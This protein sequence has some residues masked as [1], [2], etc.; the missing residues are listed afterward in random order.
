[1]KSALCDNIMSLIDYYKWEMYHLNVHAL[2]EQ[3]NLRQMQWTAFMKHG[4]LFD[5]KRDKFSN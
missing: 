4:K 3:T 1:M 5:L 2:D